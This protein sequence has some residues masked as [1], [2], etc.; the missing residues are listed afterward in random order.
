MKT[1]GRRF[2]VDANVIIRYL[3]RDDE[4]LFRQAS[5]IMEALEDERI[6]LECDPVLLGEVI[7]VL[8]SYY[9][10][11]KADISDKLQTLLKASGFLIPNKDRYLRALELYAGPVPHFG[12]ACACAAA[13][14]ECEGRLLSFDRELSAVEGIRRTES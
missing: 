6:A 13:L 2:A 14:E 4:T 1:E 10:L 8:S 7:W 12:D 3:M 11:A 5:A 9:K